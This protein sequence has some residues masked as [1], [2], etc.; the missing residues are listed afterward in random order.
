MLKYG[1]EFVHFIVLWIFAAEDFCERDHSDGQG[2]SR[3]ELAELSSLLVSKVFCD[4][5]FEFTGGKY[6]IQP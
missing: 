6:T 3:Q 2:S 5:F 1:G 4:K